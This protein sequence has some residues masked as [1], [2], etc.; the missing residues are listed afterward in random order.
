MKILGKIF[1]LG[2]LII[3]MSY[4]EDNDG[5][6]NKAPTI[7]PN[8]APDDPR[9]LTS[10]QTTKDYLRFGMDAA[11]KQDYKSAFKYFKQACDNGDPAGCFAIGTMYANGVGILTNLDKAERY[12]EMGCS[13]GDATACSSLATI[14]DSKDQASVSD[15]KKAVELYMTACQGGDVIACNNL[16][17]MY[18]NGDGVQKDYYKAMN[19]YKYACDSG[20]DLG[21]YNLGLLTNTNNIYGYN[22]ANLTPV[23]LNY[24]ACNAGDI[25]GCANL[26]WIYANGLSGAPVSYHYAARYFNQACLAGDIPSCNNLAVL[27]QKGLGVPQDTQ[28]ALDLYSYACNSGHQK[29]CDNYR[30]Y[31][32]QLIGGRRPDHG[33]LFFP[34]N[35]N[36]GKKPPLGK[37]PMRYDRRYNR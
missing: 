1:I 13:G 18:A 23:D 6:Q 7:A 14:Y 36:L 31:K 2:L 9:A 11:K 33:A 24:L 19:Y 27:Y 28:R 3:N 22:R 37:D 26:G 15:K 25:K 17:Y 29:A 20:S 30:I 10:P 16:A 35:P 34:N 5:N 8:P 12:Y 4:G 21:C 32:Q